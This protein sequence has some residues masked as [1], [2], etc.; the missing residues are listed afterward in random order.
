[1]TNEI[2]KLPPKKKYPIELVIK[3]ITKAKPKICVD[4]FYLSEN[5]FKK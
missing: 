1:M 2:I 5:L 3:K 4:D